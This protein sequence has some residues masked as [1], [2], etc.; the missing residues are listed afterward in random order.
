[1]FSIFGLFFAVSALCFLLLCREVKAAAPVAGTFVSLLSGRSLWLLG[2]IWVFAAAACLGIYFVIPLYLT[3]E[4]GLDIRYAN[5]IFGISRIGGIFVALL[6]GFLVDKVSLRKT[7]FLLTLFT[8]LLTA[9]LAWRNPS[10]IT[11][12]LFLQA[13][14]A[15]GFF[16]IGLVAIS[17]MFA[18]SR[19]SMATGLIVTLGVIFGLGIIPYLFGLA[20]DHLSFRF[21][22]LVFGMAMT[23]VSSLAWFLRELK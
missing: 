9:A 21:G 18:G 8:G 23:A 5:T 19:R 7:V 15:T 22:I 3:K 6:A 10:A 20:G 4:I 13:S 12:I 1:M 2:T 17:R 16:P 14:V 11:V